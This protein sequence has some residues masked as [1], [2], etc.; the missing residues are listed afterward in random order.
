MA[1]ITT[2]TKEIIVN[3]TEYELVYY[4]AGHIQVRE[5]ETMDYISV[6]SYMVTDNG[7]NIEIENL[8]NWFPPN[9][10]AELSEVI[11]SAVKEHFG[12]Y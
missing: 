3:Y 8:I 11:T 9:E 4:P 10:Q 1:K 5:L 2:T 12:I 6:A 7:G